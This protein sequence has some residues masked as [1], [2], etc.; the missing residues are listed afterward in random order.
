M[1]WDEFSAVGQSK[2]VGVGADL[3]G[4]GMLSGEG[5][6][7]ISKSSDLAALKTL[8]IK[9]DIQTLLAKIGLLLL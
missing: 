2:A 3:R 4:A 7:A 6:V 9:K 1:D 8:F 5:G